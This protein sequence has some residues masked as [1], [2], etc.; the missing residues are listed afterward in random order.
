MEAFEVPPTDKFQVI[1]QYRPGE[2]IYD[3]DYL[4]GPRSADFVLFYITAGRPRDTDTKRRF[5]GR[6]A[7][8]LA[9]NLRLRP[10]GCDG[11]DHHH[12]VGRVVVQR[13]ARLDDR[14]ADVTRADAAGGLWDNSA[15]ISFR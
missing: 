12:P 10:R 8:L 5:Y 3:R 15:I 14:S 6:L 11:G 7:A 1:D 13:R 4:G 2:L 9:E